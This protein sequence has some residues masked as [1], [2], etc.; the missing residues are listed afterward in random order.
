[1][2]HPPLDEQAA[3]FAHK[4]TSTVSALV[5]T[6]PPFKARAIAKSDGGEG[7]TVRQD[8]PDG[9]SL[10]VEGEPLLRLLVSFKCSLDREG[11]YLTVDAS[12]VKVLAD[13]QS[14]E[15]LFRYEYD[16]DAVEDMPAAH[17]QVHA[18]RDAFAHVMNRAGTATARGKRRA[19]LGKM[20]RLEDLHLPVGGHRFRPCLEDV[21]GMLV[22]EFG[23][24]STANGRR[25]L[26]NGREEWRRTQIRS[27]VRD[28]PQE[29][30]A[31][32]RDLGY[33]VNLEPGRDHP[34][35]NTTRLRDF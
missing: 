8:P 3:G 9:I 1:M 34:L 22:H 21:L 7:F 10:T 16:R 24:D 11:H 28:A 33:A 29:A 13:G 4:L 25:A 18:H 19:N 27:A 15:P 17:I 35:E 30:V 23:V 6:C 14:S 5:P 26:Q 31:A 32:L 2:S 20:A 12:A